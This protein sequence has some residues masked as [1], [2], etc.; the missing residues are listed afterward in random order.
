[1]RN[2]GYARAMGA[3]EHACDVLFN[4]LDFGPNLIYSN[5]TFAPAKNRRARTQIAGMPGYF[6]Y[7]DQPAGYPVPDAIKGT[8]ELWVRDAAAWGL[9]VYSGGVYA[10]PE[11]RFNAAIASRP[12]KLEAYSFNDFF[13]LCDFE[14]A[15]YTR[16]NL[17]FRISLKFEAEPYF[18][19]GT[20][21]AVEFDIGQTGSVN[22]FDPEDAT[23]DT[24]L[25]PAGETCE[26][27]DT[28]F[29]NAS[30]SGR[31]VLH[32]SPD[33]YAE[34][35]VTGLTAS[36]RYTFGIRNIYSR[37]IWQLYDGS[38]NRLL[39]WPV[40]GVTEIVFRMI[41]KSDAALAVGFADLAVYEVGSGY[42]SDYLETLDAPLKTVYCTA[43]APAR[44]IVDGAA[45]ALPVGTAVPIYGLDI[46][47]WTK[48]P[49]TVVSD[50]A[51]FGYLS[52]RRG[53]RSCTL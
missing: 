26:W 38:G 15:K 8:L 3:W 43:N 22:L 40:T 2:P 36:K 18:W 16:F 23:L 39:T 50:T 42:Q 11:A 28:A 33:N 47:P 19:E 20:A 1:M 6:D 10:S 53:A 5:L 41:S 17:G 32:A 46:P 51:C 25:L 27:D 35:H 49:I 4:G 7:S 12:C 21:R 31:Y 13:L 9:P 37:G 48:V 14:V 45:Y 44:L 34:V 24:S 29:D 52:Y 30:S